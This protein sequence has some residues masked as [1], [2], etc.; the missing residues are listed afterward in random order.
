MVKDHQ[1]IAWVFEAYILSPPPPKN[2]AFA[3]LVAV[4]GGKIRQLVTF[5]GH[6]HCMQLSA[7]L[8]YDIFSPPGANGTFTFSN[9]K[10]ERVRQA[11]C[12]R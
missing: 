1:V 12:S 8:F 10:S 5:V 6:L 4:G 7:F 3:S 11:I 9:P 2:T